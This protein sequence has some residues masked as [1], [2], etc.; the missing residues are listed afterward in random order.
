MSKTRVFIIVLFASVFL[1]NGCATS[2]GLVSLTTPTSDKAA[3]SNGMEIYIRSVVD[4]R[5]F[6]ADPKSPD[7]PSLDP[8]EPQ[9]EDIKRRAI[10]RKRNTFGKGLGDI[11]LNEGQTVVSVISDSLRQAFIEEGYTVIGNGSN[12][13]KN[14]RIVDVEINKFW[15]WMNPGFWAI[16]LSTEIGTEVIIQG[17]GDGEKKTVYVK[18]A[19][20]FQTAVEGNWLAV[21]HTALKDYIDE[22][23]T[24][25]K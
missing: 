6:E 20:H 10:A 3:P 18:A 17:A 1:L 9:N 15:S 8:S 21:M 11:L 25:I 13:A 7:I 16:T 4:K 5:V 23:K 12:L 22:V 24:R 2:R 14:S 19:D